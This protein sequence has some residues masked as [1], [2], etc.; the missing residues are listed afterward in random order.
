MFEQH[1]LNP[2]YFANPPG[3]HLSAALPAGARLRRSERGGARV[4]A[5]TRPMSTRSRAWPPRCSASRRCG[6]CMRRARASSAARVGPARGGDR[7]GRV[8]AGLL[9]ATSRSTTCRRSR[10]ST[11]SLLGSAG[12]LR[13]GRAARLPAR[14]RR[15]GPRLREQVHRRDRARWRSWPR[16]R[17]ATWRASRGAGGRALGGHR[18]RRPRRR[19]SA[20]W[21]RTPTRCSTITAFTPNSSTSR[22]CRPK[23]RA[24]WA[25]R[26][27]GGFLYYLWSLTWGLGW[28]P[29]LAALGGRA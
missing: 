25:P 4:R 27:E 7:G 6:C 9:C 22:R 8:P 15:A 1:S 26:S 5:A 24:S 29:A 17:R 18:A 2:H 16:S 19:S 13:K 20:S 28:V 12:V 14:G 23:P 10:R 11:L 3:L 21:S